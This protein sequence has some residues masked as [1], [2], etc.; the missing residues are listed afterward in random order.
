MSYDFDFIV[1][2]AGPAGQIGALT[3]ASLGQRVVL[4]ERAPE[5]GGAAVHTGTLPSKTLRESALFLSGF[6]Q[7]DLHRVEAP[8]VRESTLGPLMA[9]K[10]AV[11]QSEVARILWDLSRHDVT[12]IHGTARFAGLHEIE[13]QTGASGTLQLAGRK[14]LI[15]T[16]SSPYHPPNIPFEDHDIDDSDSI[17]LIDR[18]PDTLTVLGAGVIGC[19]YA[20]MFAALGVRV[21]L[22]EA[23]DRLLPFLDAEIAE[24]LRIALGRLGIELI[25]SQPYTSVSR[26]GDKIVTTLQNGRT[27]ASEKLLFAAGRE[28]NTRDLRLDVVGIVPDKRGYIPVNKQF[29]TCVPHIYAAGDVVGFPALASTS[30]EQGR[31]AARHAFGAHETDTLPTMLPYGIYTIPEVS[32]VGETEESCKRKAIPYEVG[33]ALYRD[34]ARG[35]II[36]DVEGMVKLLFRADE[37]H[38]L[39]GVHILGERACE[40]V[41]IGQVALHLGASIDTFVDMV[42]NYPTLSMCYQQAAYDGLARLAHRRSN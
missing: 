40:L 32:M 5:P 4:I 9:R 33:R 28:G 15:A 12:L 2:G 30:M 6:R 24:R 23:R 7:R 27:V 37:D 10:D 11:R 39:L 19:E 36:G 16:G 31:I 20:S 25:L 18:L 8:L 14:I 13:V 26:R 35:K 38:K 21:T 29:Q 17:L 42:F 22:V 3:A 1:I 34:N 41:H